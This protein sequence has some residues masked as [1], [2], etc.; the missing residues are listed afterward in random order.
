MNI[1]FTKT[2]KLMLDEHYNLLYDGEVSNE[3]YKEICETLPLREN[4]EKP[5]V[6]FSNMGSVSGDIISIM[7]SMTLQCEEMNRHNVYVYEN[8]T[9]DDFC[10][11]VLK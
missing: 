2:K 9:T 10:Y 4:G 5:G 1:H 11:C 8:S 6:I 7:K 3:K